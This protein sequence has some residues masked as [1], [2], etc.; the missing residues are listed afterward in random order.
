MHRRRV[1][2]APCGWRSAAAALPYLDHYT[3]IYAGDLV[4]LVRWLPTHLLVDACEVATAAVGSV[5]H[6]TLML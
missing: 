6:R 4:E 1:H 3:G 2:A 5:K